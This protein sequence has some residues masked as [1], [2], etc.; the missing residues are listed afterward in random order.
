MQSSA[1]SAVQIHGERRVGICHDNFVP[2][3][4]KGIGTVAAG[5]FGRGVADI[6]NFHSFCCFAAAETISLALYA[7]A[8][9]PLARCDPSLRFRNPLTQREP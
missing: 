6:K 1:Q 7:V 8:L 2:K 5:R 9:A 3:P 4:L